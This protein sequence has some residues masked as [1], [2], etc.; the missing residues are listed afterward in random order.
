MRVDGLV[1]WFDFCRDG[2]IGVPLE[3]KNGTE[4]LPGS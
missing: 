3:L 4:F 1:C 2:Q